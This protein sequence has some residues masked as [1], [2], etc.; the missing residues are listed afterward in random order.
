MIQN[1]HIGQ[2]R[3]PFYSNDDLL[4]DFGAIGS[5]T[6]QKQRPVIYKLGIQADAGTIVSINNTNIKI[7]NTGIYQLDDIIKINELSFPNGASENTII[8]FIYAGDAWRR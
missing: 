1:G 6:P 3:G 5:F 2:V 8:D 7:G 4:A